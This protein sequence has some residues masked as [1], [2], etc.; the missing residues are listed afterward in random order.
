MPAWIQ[1][2]PRKRQL[3]VIPTDDP[4]EQLVFP[5]PDNPLVS[6]IIPVHNK[7]AFT[8][9]CL[10]A[11]LDHTARGDYEVIVADDN[12][13]DET[14][15]MGSIAQNVLILRDGI[16][17]GF[18]EN[19]NQAAAHARG[20][21]FIFLNN[22]TVPQPNWLDPLLSLAEH[23]PTVG[24][25][26]PKMVDESGRL[27]EAG[28]I[29]FRDASAVNYGRG[30]DPSSPEV[31]YVKDVDYV[32]GACLLVRASLWRQIGGFDPRYSPG[33]YEDSDLAFEVR[34]RGFR[35]VYQPQALVVHFE[36]ISHGRDTSTGLKSFQAVNAAKFREKWSEVLDRDQLSHDNVYLARDRS[37]GPCRVLVVDEHVPRY[38]HDAGSRFVWSYLNLFLESGSHVVF[39]SESAHAIEPYATELQQR[40]IEL[41]LGPWSKRRRDKWLGEHASWFDSA[42][43]HRPHIAAKYLDPLR[44][45]SDAKIVYWPADLH[46]V[47]ERRRWEVT[48]DEDARLLADELEQQELALV[49]SADV[50]QVVSCYEEEIL[51]RVA[52]KA[53]VQT[54]PVVIYDDPP[55]NDNPFELRQGVMFVG[56][57]LHAPN[58]NAAVWFAR[59]IYPVVRKVIPDASFRIVG[60]NPPGEIT[61]LAGNGVSVTGWVDDA[62][63]AELYRQTRVV[64]CPLRFGAGAKGKLVESLYFGVPAVVTSVAAEGLVEIEGH[65]LIADE[66][67]EFGALVVE[68][69]T[70]RMMWENLAATAPSYVRT[71]FSHTAAREALSL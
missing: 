40:G 12:S 44:I 51:R 25:V 39:L 32:S 8:H 64:V 15:G 29:I 35:V 65:V 55:A 14:R 1:T 27:Q 63:L 2:E 20:D 34:R 33:Y 68:L 7:W 53:A 22:D 58:C 4:M 3:P 67:A 69:Y 54:I 17:R 47:R 16:Q 5:P 71:H 31:N 37:R 9:L 24:I 56:G 13:S 6:I 30:G 26:G 10:R 45:H 70:N 21:Y 23:D 28:G 41:V 57:F 50:T 52:P 42:Y 38:D 48:H 49:N 61:E 36:G 19:C 18:L 43:L 60:S 66:P 11:V 62:T 46:H 59:E